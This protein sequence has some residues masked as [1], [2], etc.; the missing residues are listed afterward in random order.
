M[1][2]REFIAGLGGAATW[3]LVARAQPGERVRRVGVLIGLEESDREAQQHFTAF[4]QALP[5][6]GW[7]ENDNLRIVARWAAGSVE[8][9][10]NYAS[11]LISLKPDVIVVNTPIGLAALQDGTIARCAAA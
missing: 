6:L 7:T 9:T 5:K 3:P 11:E 10:R 1:K 4:R 2:R 8:A